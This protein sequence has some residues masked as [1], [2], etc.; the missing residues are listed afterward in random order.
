MNRSMFCELRRCG[1]YRGV[2]RI[3][4]RER[5]AL[6]VRFWFDRDVAVRALHKR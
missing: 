2:W 6:S 4:D 3:Y 5:E 1:E